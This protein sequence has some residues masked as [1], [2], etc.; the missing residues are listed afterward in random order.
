MSSDS[1]LTLDTRETN[2][3]LRTFSYA[4]DGDTEAK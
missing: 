1:C 4:M 3:I 2:L